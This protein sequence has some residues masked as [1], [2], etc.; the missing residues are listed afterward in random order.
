MKEIIIKIMMKKKST[1]KFDFVL[2]IFDSPLDI[3]LKLYIIKRNITR[4]ALKKLENFAKKVFT[5]EKLCAII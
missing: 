5:N 1:I 2:L 3:F 4:L